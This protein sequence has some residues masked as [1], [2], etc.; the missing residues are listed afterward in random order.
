MAKYS[1]KK[2]KNGLCIMTDFFYID[3]TKIATSIV[4]G[5]M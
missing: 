5:F 2:P 3:S 4:H 1:F